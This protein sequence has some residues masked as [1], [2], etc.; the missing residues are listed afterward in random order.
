MHTTEPTLNEL[1]HEAAPVQATSDATEALSAVSQ[2]PTPAAVE[3]SPPP[4]A[5]APSSVTAKPA[6]RKTPT[7]PA[8]K[9]AVSK[10]PVVQAAAKPTVAKKAAAKPTV[11]KPA[12]TKPAAA[13]SAATKPAVAKPAVAKKAAAKPAV[14]KPVAAK[15]AT[16]TRPVAKAP[17]ETTASGKTKK[18][19][20]VRDSF[21]I[22]KP[23]YQL[24]DDIKRRAQMLAHPAK[25]SEILRA[26]IKALSA[27]ADA[28]LVAALTAVPAIKTGRPASKDSAQ[29]DKSN[30][31]VRSS[32]R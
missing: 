29:Q 2:E 24:L 3:V 26:G 25:K 7:K 28:A 30:K 21:T 9:K 6:P 14:A 13:K 27:L 22:P 1:P 31:K 19:K 12:A 4:L 18:A 10:P 15:K 5:A 16:P 8:V 17:S 23:E 11:A 20:L 32:K